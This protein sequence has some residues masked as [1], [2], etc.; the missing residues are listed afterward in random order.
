VKDR[1]ETGYLGAMLDAEHRL[2]LVP[3][4]PDQPWVAFRRMRSWMKRR[5]VTPESSV[6][7][8]TAPPE[9]Q[10]AEVIRLRTRLTLDD[11]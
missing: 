8:F 11:D 5:K 7:V 2:V 4:D 9:S 10:G 1:E 6:D 3:L